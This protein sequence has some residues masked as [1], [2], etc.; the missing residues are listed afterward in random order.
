MNLQVDLRLK[1]CLEVEGAEAG[2]VSPH[3][4]QG[5][6]R[7]GVQATHPQHLQPREHRQHR[8]QAGPRHLRLRVLI[9]VT[10]IE[11][12]LSFGKSVINSSLDSCCNI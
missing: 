3:G 5:G 6:V 12:E 4:S 9:N 7:D 11:V 2:E 10:W 1:L 8:L